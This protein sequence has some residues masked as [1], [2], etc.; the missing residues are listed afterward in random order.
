MSQI[1]WAAVS[2]SS[3]G[4]LFILAPMHSLTGSTI[5]VLVIFALSTMNSS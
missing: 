4:T 2:E 3:Q 1:R 5:A